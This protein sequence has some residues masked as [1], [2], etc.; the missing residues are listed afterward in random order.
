MRRPPARL[1]SD[2]SPR[3]R[4][5]A[6]HLLRNLLARLRPAPDG[7]GDAAL[8]Q[9]FVAQRDEA[10]FELLV[11]R[12]ERLVLGVCRRVLGNEHDADDAFQAT[13]LILARKAHS[14]GRREVLASWLYKVA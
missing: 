9:R 10:A 4:L 1:Y 5:M 11:W 2:R 7:V 14:V 13:W 12:H 8:L 6:A 3:S